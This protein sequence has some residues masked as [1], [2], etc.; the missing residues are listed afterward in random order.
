VRALTRRAQLVIGGVGLAAGVAGAAAVVG[1]GYVVPLG[2]LGPTLVLQL[3]IPWSFIG[4]GLAAWRRRPDSRIGLLMVVFGFAYLARFVI[5]IATP[6]AF[7]IGVLV[8]GVNVAVQTHIMV[9]YPSGRISTWPQRLIVWAAYLLTLP[10]AL[11]LLLLGM[12]PY[13]TEPLLPGLLIFPTPPHPG[14]P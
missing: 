7:A 14:H 3:A 5:A 11:L 13:P 10:R 8:A 1:G 2:L 6:A 4:A 12:V 9:T